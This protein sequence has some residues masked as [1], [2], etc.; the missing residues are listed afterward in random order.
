[1]A[2]AASEQQAMSAGGVPFY[3][4]RRNQQPT[5]ETI[6]VESPGPVVNPNPTCPREPRAKK[7]K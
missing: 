1:M 7:N 2:D 3:R 6:I 4:S 5:L